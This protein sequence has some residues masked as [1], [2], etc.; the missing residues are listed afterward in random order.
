MF[1]ER[2]R[3]RA[4][5]R[6]GRTVAGRG[7]GHLD[8]STRGDRRRLHAFVTVLDDAARRDA[9]SLTRRQAAGEPP[10]PLHG[11]PVS[12]KDLIAVGGAPLTFG[13]RTMANNVA[14]ADAAA[15]ERLRRAGAIIIG[16]TTTSEFG[17]K[18]V[19]DSPLTGITRNPGTRQDRGR[20]ERRG[21]GERRGRRHGDRVGTEAAARSGFPPR[22]AACSA[23]RRSSAVCR[24][25]R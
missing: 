16:K 20:L 8:G 19:G 9:A 17:C 5:D 3:D 11:V 2:A 18:A 12:V 10:G 7:A 23:S 1:S 14:E 22:C 15:V 25:F 13:S 24:Y 6:V 4:P 21:G